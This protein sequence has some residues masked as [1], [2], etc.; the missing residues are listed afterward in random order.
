VG[1]SKLSFFFDFFSRRKEREEIS[2]L[3]RRLAENEE[4]VEELIKLVNILA[5]F[6]K[7]MAQ[8]IRS[9]ASHVALMELSMLDKKKSEKVAIRRRSND[10]DLIN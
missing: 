9:V 6:D 2:D 4:K 1:T 10:D 8:D 7:R 3:R 5:T